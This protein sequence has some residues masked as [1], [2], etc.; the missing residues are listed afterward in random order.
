MSKKLLEQ[1]PYDANQHLNR[2]GTAFGK[3]I[4][5]KLDVVPESVVDLVGPSSMRFFNILGLDTSFLKEDPATW[6]LSPSYNEAYSVVRKLLFVNDCAER[7]VKLGSDFINSSKTEE[8][9]QNVLQVVENDRNRV[10][11][12]RLPKK[13]PKHWFLAVNDVQK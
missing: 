5:P 7:G 3:P 1:P 11:N 8:R 12:Q 9:W 4:F 10:S 2:H 6:E 13:E